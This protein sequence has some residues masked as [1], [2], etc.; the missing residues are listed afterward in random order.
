[1]S[2]KPDQ[3]MPNSST[4][5]LN[6]N[7]VADAAAAPPAA[8]PGILL[9]VPS[10]SPASMQELVQNVAAAFPEEQAWI[11]SPDQPADEQAG[12]VRVV[13]NPNAHPRQD[14][15]LTA[16]DYLC[17]GNLAREHNVPAVLMLGSQAA[18]V[19]TQRLREMVGQ[20]RG[21]NVDLVLAR[22]ST[23]PGEGLVN[24]ALLYPLTRALF[25]ADI[26]FPLPVEA[27]LSQRMSQHLGI[28]AQRLNASTQGD[29]LLWP[30]PEA[31]VAGFSVRQVAAPELKL[32]HAPEGDFNTLFATVAGS[33]FADIEAK[34]TFWQR[35]RSLIHPNAAK[36]PAPVEAPAVSDEVR[37]L[38]EGFR[39]AHSNLQDLWSLVLP[40][41]TLLAL[42]RLSQ[43][44]PEE[45][46]IAP[47]LWAHIA[48]DFALAHR[49]RTLNRG[50]LLGAFTPLY[51]AWV[52]SHIRAADGSESQ[53]ALLIAAT[54]A[55]FEAEKPYLVSRWRWPDRFNP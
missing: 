10:L 2:E 7:A 43:A 17:A 26:Q 54:A 11:A 55:A 20:V 6:A 32:P 23:A 36:A 8:T 1:M 49:L 13:T 3:R 12:N 38:V 24:S 40:P 18:N 25:G 46:S 51:L 14:W 9:S 31:A 5:E 47:K 16:G 53:A 39:L 35:A 44:T 37:S 30:V 52:A 34:A 33:L 28:A 4:L 19:S 50:H 42:K 45:F 21:R 22:P 27:A 41:Q 29:A 48:F 15:V